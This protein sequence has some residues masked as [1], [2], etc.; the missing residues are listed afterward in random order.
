MKNYGKFKVMKNQLKENMKKMKR[1][2]KMNQKLEI[3]LNKCKEDLTNP[4]CLH[5]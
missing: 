3:K 2:S 1:K 5:K 4:Q